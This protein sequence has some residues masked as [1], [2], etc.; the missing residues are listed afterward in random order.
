[1]QSDMQKRRFTIQDNFQPWVPRYP[2]LGIQLHLLT[3]RV[4]HL[5]P[6]APA[7]LH[8]YLILHS[9]ATI[10]LV[11]SNKTPMAG[12]W[13]FTF[14]WLP[15]TSTLYHILL[16]SMYLNPLPTTS[17]R[18]FGQ[19]VVKGLKFTSSP[20]LSSISRASSLSSSTDSLYL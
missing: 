3:L 4:T 8:C 14:L 9:G 10:A 7:P 18:L 11:S 2:D 20:T 5:L 17:W 15:G 19:S 13:F 12:F 6:P 16:P 1:M